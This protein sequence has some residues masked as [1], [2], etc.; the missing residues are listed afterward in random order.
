MAAISSRVLGASPG[1]FNG[2]N[3]NDTPL[4]NPGRFGEAVDDATAAIDLN[5]EDTEILALAHVTRGVALANLGRFGEAEPDLRAVVELLP[6]S[7]ERAQFA[8]DA[9]EEL[10]AD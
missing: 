1:T 6:A 9:L 5:P 4:A 3:G 7:D 2:G 10:D 8:R